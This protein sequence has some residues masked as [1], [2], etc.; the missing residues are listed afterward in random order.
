[1]YNTDNGETGRYRTTQSIK[2]KSIRTIVIREKEA[3]KKTHTNHTNS[4]KL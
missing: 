4:I 2:D 3:D 1:M